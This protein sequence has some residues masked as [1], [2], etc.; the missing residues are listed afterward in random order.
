MGGILFARYATASTG[1]RDAVDRQ[2][3]DDRQ[4]QPQRAPTRDQ[5]I[6]AATVNAAA[7][8]QAPASGGLKPGQPAD[9]A[10][11]DGDPFTADTRVTQTWVS[12]QP[13]WTR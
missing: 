2:L 10:I 12:G 5:A 3:P 4:L 7:S 13:A 8:P 11:C 9:L 1:Q 6:R